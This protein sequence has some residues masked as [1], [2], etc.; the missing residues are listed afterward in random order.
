MKK[1]VMIL[2]LYVSTLAAVFSTKAYAQ[3][4]DTDIDYEGVIDYREDIASAE[5]T[6]GNAHGEES[7]TVSDN[8]I[9]DKA[10]QMYYYELTGGE[11]GMNVPS[12]AITTE[13][14][15]LSYTKGL[16][17]AIYCDGNKVESVTDDT[18]TESGRYTVLFDALGKETVDFTIAPEVT[19]LTYG[20]TVPDGFKIFSAIY[21]GTELSSASYVDMTKEGK[22]SII[23][24]SEDAGTRHSFTVTVDHTP[25]ELLLEAVVDGYADGPVDISDKPE[26]ASITIL[27]NDSEIAYTKELTRSGTY[28]ITLEDPAG[29]KSTYQFVIRIY[30]NFNSWAFLGILALVIVV[31]LAYLIYSKKTLRVR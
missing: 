3:D 14:V 15:K 23:Y 13:P 31:I 9:Y 12:G 11:I 18:L 30:F 28:K 17:P 21:D 29:N 24:G 26:D 5:I 22:Y 6:E 27:L 10:D 1:K 8:V 16:S 7:V 25:P 4:A 20:F 19:S 2:L